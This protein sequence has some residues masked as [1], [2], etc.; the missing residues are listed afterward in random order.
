MQT[1]IES[2]QPILACCHQYQGPVA[3]WISASDFGACVR[4]HLKVLGS[5][6]SGIVFCSLGIA[7]CYVT[8]LHSLWGHNASSCTCRGPEHTLCDTS[9]PH[10][11]K[12]QE[13]YACL[14][15]L[16]PKQA[17]AHTSD[18]NTIPSWDLQTRQCS[19]LANAAMAAN[20]ASPGCLWCCCPI[21]ASCTSNAP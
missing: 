21:C 15:A 20:C 19:C 10:V 1:F 7:F 2:Y 13:M 3:Q 18:M 11:H 4:S 14:L 6:P 12:V 9:M 8:T 17:D 16:P 5:I